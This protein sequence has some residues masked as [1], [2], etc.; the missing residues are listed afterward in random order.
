MDET[1]W[2]EGKR[3]SSSSPSSS[4]TGLL[5]ERSWRRRNGLALRNRCPPEREER[6]TI[7]IF[8]GA[9]LLIE[10]AL[11]RRPF[12]C[13]WNRLASKHSRTSTSMSSDDH[14]F[15][16][17]NVHATMERGSVVPAYSCSSGSTTGDATAAARSPLPASAERGGRPCSSGR[18]TRWRRFGDSA[19]SGGRTAI[20][21]RCAAMKAGPGFD[22]TAT[23]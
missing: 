9:Y 11:F 15:S 21:G 8:S 4:R 18:S 3:F 10:G 20:S 1:R 5:V 7:K 19:F 17:A 22:G 6:Q 16:M 13:F 2:G 23:S 14:Y 12:L